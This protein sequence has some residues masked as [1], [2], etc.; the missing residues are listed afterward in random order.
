M[1]IDDQ[2]LETTIK[3]YIKEYLEEHLKVETVKHYP[4][5]DSSGSFEVKLVLDGEVI[6]SDSI[7]L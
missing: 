6:S 4:D 3:H 5:Y 2:M 1:I 7:Y